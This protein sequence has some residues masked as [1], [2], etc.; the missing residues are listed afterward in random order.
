MLLVSISEIGGG[1]LLFRIIGLYQLLFLV[2]V[3]PTLLPSIFCILRLFPLPSAR[4][5]F[6]LFH[7][8]EVLLVQVTSLIY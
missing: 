3:P 5:G 4:G 7:H 1:C 6:A 2:R 8:S